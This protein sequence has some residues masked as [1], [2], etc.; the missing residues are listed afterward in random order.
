MGKIAV[1]RA[2]GSRNFKPFVSHDPDIYQLVLSEDDYFL[3]LAC[4]G[5]WD[6][7]SDQDASDIV[8]ASQDPQSAASKL[9]KSALERGSGDNVSVITIFFKDRNQWN[10]EGPT[11]ITKNDT[12]QFLVYCDGNYRTPH[13]CTSGMLNKYEEHK[14][15]N[16]SEEKKE[17]VPQVLST[18]DTTYSIASV[19]DIR[20]TIHIQNSPLLE[21]PN[22]KSSTSLTSLIKPMAVD[23]NNNIEMTSLNS[24]P[25][26]SPK[27]SHTQK[28]RT[29]KLRTKITDTTYPLQPTSEVSVKKNRKLAISQ[30]LSS[31]L[32]SSSQPDQ[33]VKK[34]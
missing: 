7:I 23:D 5:I 16:K 22:L 8:F 31:S 20:E 25:L 10:T 9:I 33:K 19:S 14:I 1:S 27:R 6:V 3:V 12:A 26:K 17:F 21:N 2:L 34:E 15:K 29:K 24:L 13:C 30:S 4:D 32:K 11:L 18:L 28:L